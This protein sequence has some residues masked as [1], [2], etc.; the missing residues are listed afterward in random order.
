MILNGKKISLEILSEIQKEVAFIKGRKPAL[1]VIL[2]GENPASMT[3]V[4]AK[5]KACIQVGMTS[6]VLHLSN[7]LSQSDL[8]KTIERLNQDT[9][10][11]GILVQLPLPSHINETLVT[12]MIDP[13][14]DVDGFHPNNM[15]KLLLGES[16]GLQPCTPLGI[17]VLLEKANV[18]IAGKH[19]VILGRSNIVGKPLAAIL[20]Q[21]EKGCNATVTIAHTQ[22]KNL[23]EITQSAD[24]LVAAI[25]KS[26]FVT[27]KMVKPNAVVIDVG[28]NRIKGKLVG[29]VDFEQV[30]ETASKI[31]PVPG[32]IGPM[33][34]A[35]LLKNTLRAFSHFLIVLFLLS[36]CQK[37]EPKDPCTYFRGIYKNERY[38]IAI[39]KTLSKKDEEILEKTIQE[40]F[41]AHENLFDLEKSTSELSTLNHSPKD[42]HIPLSVPM[43]Y[44]LELSEKVV[45]ISNHRFD[46]TIEPIA[47]AWRENDDPDL[48]API[49]ATGWK[50]ISVH[51]GIL[52]K[53]LDET[54]L[55][56]GGIA[57][58][59]L[60]DELSNRINELGIQD[61][62]VQWS[63]GARAKGHHPN[64]QDWVVQVNPG[65]T[66][67][68]Q[69]IA[70]IPLRDAAI[71]TSGTHFFHIIDPTTAYP[72]QKT[73]FSIASAAVIAPNCA[74]A[75][76]LATASM[77][78][79][80]R[81]EAENWAEEVVDSYSDVSFWIVSYRNEP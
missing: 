46:P 44:L 40:T 16:E 65:L 15:G 76:G 6:S 57:K 79:S 25:G 71:A 2:V 30:K 61:Y 58:G 34:I 41:L 69:E 9:N 49:E 72:I 24:V 13:K 53:E 80:T 32:G 35:M 18:D 47:K 68:N 23:T 21:K 1:T 66:I 8:L 42:I 55:N 27:K 59:F 62:L 60:V 36:S 43:Q 11:D 29:D 4:N 77:L 3:Y 38:Q 74:F 14:K 73:S 20:M 17:K 67:N 12:A 78:F 45:T 10:V 22:T 28:I 63:G 75:D 48:Q 19:V 56:L 50:H 26:Q 70:P 37:S 64:A 33:T 54:Q 7:R 52:K 81:R 51:N 39:G 31:T 5:K